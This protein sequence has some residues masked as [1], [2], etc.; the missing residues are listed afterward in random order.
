MAASGTRARRTPSRGKKLGDSMS[1]QFPLC[2][3]RRQ[4]TGQNAAKNYCAK[5]IFQ[6]LWNDNKSPGSSLDLKSIA[7]LFSAVKESPNKREL[8]TSLSWL[9]RRV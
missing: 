4:I 7:K 8:A 3:V 6:R 1:R 5:Y 2:K 9:E